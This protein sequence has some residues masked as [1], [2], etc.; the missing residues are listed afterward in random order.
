[1][2]I[3]AERVSGH[4]HRPEA[5]TAGDG[6]KSDT[7]NW[8]EQPIPPEKRQEI[9]GR[10]AAREHAR[11]AE[12]RLAAEATAARRVAEVESRR[13]SAESRGNEL[14]EQLERERTENASTV[15]DLRRT[16]AEREASI[17]AEERQA[18]EGAVSERIAGLEAS[19]VALRS[20][21][22]RKLADAARSHALA[23]EAVQRDAGEHDRLAQ[24]QVA[25]AE[26]AKN[27][28]EERLR[29]AGESKNAEI[30]QRVAEVR[31]VME[32]EKDVAVRAEQSKHF[33]E[34]DGLRKTIELLK[35]KVE[36]RT[37]H[38]LGEGAE[39]DL[40]ETLKGA[41]EDDRIRRVKKGVAGA[42]IV[43]EI[44][45]NGKVCGKIIYD[46]KNRKDWK[47]AYAAKLHA[48]QIS[49]P[50]DQAILVSQFFPT[51]LGQLH[52]C[53]GVIVAAPK[54]VVT[55]VGIVREH[56]VRLHELRV[57]NEAREEKTEALYEFI[58][59]DECEQLLSSFE[60]M[61]EEVM[62]LD[63]AEKKAHDKMWANRGKL[64]STMLKRHGELCRRIDRIIGTVD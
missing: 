62:E 42:D 39:I 60:D 52:V 35:R 1:M 29:V 28:A 55:V 17:R 7:C 4:A 47:P 32:N 54:R 11:D 38:D 59:S 44:V 22:D 40:F 6:T 50:A 43:H 61:L 51:G 8:C 16:A 53:E 27:A 56:L 64:L 20:E 12:V 15:E 34:R 63:V 24:E 2:A 45:H 58:V 9:L 18:A 21:T 49:E 46:A 5:Y 48:D 14:A 3:P 37:A 33:E 31:S 36:N 57:S 25:A 30:E 19:N 13:A 23:L 41:F 26:R 10:I